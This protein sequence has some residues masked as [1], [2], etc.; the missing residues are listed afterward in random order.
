MATVRARQ[1]AES[2]AVTTVV[3]PEIREEVARV[4]AYVKRRPFAPDDLEGAWLAVAAATPEVNRAVATAAEE[5]RIFVN[6]VDD[7]AR[8]SA[9]AASVIRRGD[10]ILAISTEGRAP[11]LAT[12]LRQSLE[13]LLPCEISSWVDAA[14]AARL[15]W[16]RARVPVSRRRPLLLERLNALYARALDEAPMPPGSVSLV[17]AGPGDPG[18]LSR[19]AADRLAQ[20]DVVLYDALVH[21]AA[22][23]LAPRAHCF[24][25]GK[26]A[27]CPS[28]S[29]RAI[30]RLLVH[31]AK[32]GKRVVRLKCGDPFVFGRGGEEAAALTAAGVPFE[33]VPGIS[34]ALAA[35]ALAGI[36]VTH[37]GLAAGFMVISGHAA[38]SYRPLLDA[39]P[40][41]ALTL[42]VLMGIS[43]R[44]RIAACLRSRGWSSE[45]PAA[46]VLGAA[47]EDAFTWVGTLAD[48][49]AEELPA[50][51]TGLPGTIVVGAVAALAATKSP[52][53]AAASDR[54]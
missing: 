49:G 45:T 1:L 29:Q 53:R 41:N 19:R 44:A 11:A 6:A 37:R 39:L 48:L 23:R 12:L 15:E 50:D 14:E 30:E 46:I 33:V 2:G 22:L 8:A 32:R 40:P 34:A 43:E 28:V 52:P 20:A 16:K 4:A 42:V 47:R 9:Y 26:R 17:G 51:R 10:A 3:A 24:L 7:P 38:S 21:P 36:P 13:A 18:L 31:A 5:R 35:P 54:R 27:G 25:V